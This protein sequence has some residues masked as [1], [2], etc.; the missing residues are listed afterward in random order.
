M[1]TASKLRKKK[2]H[3]TVKENEKHSK[4]II[5]I[6]NKICRLLIRKIKKQ[7]YKKEPL[8]LAIQIKTTTASPTYIIK[9]NINREEVYFKLFFGDDYDKSIIANLIVGYFARR[10]FSVSRS[11]SLDKLFNRYYDHIIHITY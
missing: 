1:D 6:T 7:S 11:Y 5:K 2:L 8:N 9:A 4:R 3:R 10:G